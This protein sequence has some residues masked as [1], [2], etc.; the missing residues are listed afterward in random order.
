MRPLIAALF[1]CLFSFVSVPADARTHHGVRH[2]GA[3]VNHVVHRSARHLRRAHRHHRVHRRAVHQKP[4]PAVTIERPKHI[5]V[6]NVGPM[7]LPDAQPTIPAEL[8]AESFASLTPPNDPS[9]E[10][11]TDPV[12]DARSYLVKTAFAGGTMTML[13][14]DKSIACLHPQFAVHLAEAVKDARE[15]GL[16]GVG[17]LSACRPPALGVGG[18]ADKFNS[19]HAYGLAVDMHGIGSPGSSQAKLW[20]KIAARHDVACVYGPYNGAEWNHCQGTRVKVAP[21]YL[22]KTITAKGPIDLGVMWRVASALLVNV[23][24]AISAPFRATVPVEQRR[25]GR[26]HRPHRHS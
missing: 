15:N 23:S 25:Y 16:S 7:P 14:K 3:H 1:L 17:A 4:L 10:V 19:L 20:H 6:A 24:D 9:P 11:A 8:I 2:H 22:R 18:F 21:S 12:A 13:G 5:E 26:R